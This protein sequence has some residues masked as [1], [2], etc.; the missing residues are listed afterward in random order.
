MRKS[1]EEAHE[2][3]VVGRSR[4]GFGSITHFKDIGIERF[5]Y[6]WIDSPRSKSLSEDFLKPLLNEPNAQELL[7]T[8]EIYMESRGRL[9]V[10]AAQ[11][12]IHRNSLRYRLD[13]I[14]HLLH[15]DVDDSTTQLVLQLA[16]KAL[17]MEN[18]LHKK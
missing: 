4:H 16:L 8:L 2:A 6:G 15:V 7:E 17:N 12:K 13:R 9:S 3:L 14:S 5:L 1:F 11:L 10:A 18:K